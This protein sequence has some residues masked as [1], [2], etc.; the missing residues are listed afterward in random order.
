MSYNWSAEN[1]ALMSGMIAQA[2]ISNPTLTATVAAAEGYANES[3]LIANAIFNALD[4]TVVA[5]NQT[6]VVSQVP[7]TVIQ[8][9]DSG[10]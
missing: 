5:S 2:L 10:A 8:R 4:G 3:V 1:R 7:P 9:P 6:Q